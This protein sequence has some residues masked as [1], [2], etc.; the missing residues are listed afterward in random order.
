MST[1]KLLSKEFVWGLAT[2]QEI[3][4]IH[5]LALILTHLVPTYS[6][7]SDRGKRR[8]RRAGSLYMGHVLQA[9]WQNKRWWKWR[10]RDG[11]VRSVEGGCGFVERIQRE[12]VPLL[13]QL[14]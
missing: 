14:E 7:L 10:R 5:S 4:N 6:C 9:A 3:L 12:S 13:H 8:R 1:T 2:G 11:L